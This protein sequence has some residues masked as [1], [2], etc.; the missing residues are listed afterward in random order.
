MPAKGWE[1]LCKA[2]WSVRLN[3]RERARETLQRGTC[4][5][6]FSFRYQMERKLFAGTDLLLGRELEPLALDRMVKPIFDPQRV[7]EEDLRRFLVDLRRTRK[8]EE[9]VVRELNLDRAFELVDIRRHSP[10][11]HGSMHRPDRW[12][13]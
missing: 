5:Y 9:G 4:T 11:L 12:P 1:Q 13:L 7:E 10:R 8:E 3:T 2:L 6:L